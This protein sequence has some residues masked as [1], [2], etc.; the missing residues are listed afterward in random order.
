MFRFN[1]LRKWN[2]CPDFYCYLHSHIP[3]GFGCLAV[4]EMGMI[5]IAEHG[6]GKWLFSLALG[7]HFDGLSIAFG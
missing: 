6:C 1:H 2:E 3:C 7:V 4:W 5:A